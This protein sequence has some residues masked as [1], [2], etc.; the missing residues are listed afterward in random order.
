MS[1]TKD[2]NLSKEKGGTMSLG[3]FLC[4]FLVAA[5]LLTSCGKKKTEEA[6]QSL[7]DLTTTSTDT[8]TDS[9][10]IFD[11]FFEEE[12]STEPEPEP[13][14]EPAYTPEFVEDGNYVVQVSC[15]G[16][17]RLA[18]E[19]AA[20][21]QDRGWPAYVAEVET[22]TPELPG[23][24]YR[25]RIGS[26]FGVSAAKAFGENVL[27]PEGYDFW[28]DNKSND[29]VGVSAYGMGGTASTT[30]DYGDEYYETSTTE[31]TDSWGSSSTTE[32]STSS[33]DWGSSSTTTSS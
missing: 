10:D 19:N 26:F 17:Q 13:T 3:K 20:K 29:N 4:L 5:V 27:L 16:S 23:T 22:P 32:S 33:S 12:A 24:Y 21:L 2:T 25:I 8:A 9:S 14:Y 28:V 7:T 1:T 6:E 30:S 15:V 31:S 11:E 18:E